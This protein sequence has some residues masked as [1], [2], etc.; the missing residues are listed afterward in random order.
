MPQLS[1][2]SQ[3]RIQA[4]QA[5]TERLKE[6]ARQ[7][8]RNMQEPVFD[9]AMQ[10]LEQQRQS[11]LPDLHGRTVRIDEDSVAALNELNDE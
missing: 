4:Y 6:K 5:K 8:R 2:A 1:E 9:E 11:N 7:W 3:A 10:L